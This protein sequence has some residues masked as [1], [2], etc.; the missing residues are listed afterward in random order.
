MESDRET[1]FQMLVFVFGVF[2]M[3]VCASDTFPKAQNVTWSSIN[4][5]TMLT[6]SPKPKDYSY[7]VE[8]YEIGQSRERTP[9][10]I[11]STE[12]DCDLTTEL[13]DLRASYKA[14]ILS[15]HMRGVTSDLIEH[16][17]TTSERFSP[18]SDTVIGRP[19][20]K[21]EV[22]SDKRKITLHVTD[23]PT[24]LY[25]ERKERLSIR[26]VFKDELQYKVIYRKAKSTGKKEKISKSSTIELTD[27]DRDVS[28]CF[29]VQAYLA[30][31][32][33]DKQ[34][35]EMSHIQCSPEENTSIFDEYGAGVI[36]G[37]IL[38]IILALSA[39]I[40][41]IVMCHRR[42]KRVKNPGKEGHPL[43]HV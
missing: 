28:Y 30:F 42:R 14:D 8:F 17:Y 39:I 16:P 6:W 2:F 27:L 5:K 7:T 26:D 4:F 9:H 21:L 34:L 23:V 12:T 3:S 18:Y 38:I 24:A 41:T 13:K 35:G 32:S 15:E 1:R 19:E 20:F 33:T 11:R 25:N 36:A 10:C 40:I 22:D 37:A 29:N 31:R 43:N